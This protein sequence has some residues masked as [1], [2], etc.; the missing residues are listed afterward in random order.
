MTEEKLQINGNNMNYSIN[1]TRNIDFPKVKA[2]N[3]MSILHN[4]QNINML[5]KNKF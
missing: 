2:W 3:Y 1:E 4:T 5:F